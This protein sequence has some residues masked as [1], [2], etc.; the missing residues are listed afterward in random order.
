L[1]ST[2]ICAAAAAV[3]TAGG[4]ISVTSAVTGAPGLSLRTYVSEAGV[5]GYPHATAFRAGILA[6]A[7]GLAL[8]GVALLLR[9]APLAPA[10]L[11]AAAAAAVPAG[12]VRCTGGCP[13]PPYE[14]T[15][16]E[17]AV[18]GAASVLAVGAAVGAMLALARSGQDRFLRIAA[19]VAAAPVLPLGVVVGLALLLLGRGVVIGVI[20]RALLAIVGAWLLT[21]AL[22]LATTPQPTRRPP[23]PR[24]V[25]QG[26]P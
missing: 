9:R 10:L 13:L 26:P 24:A 4:A 22:R 2:R 3:C 6:L 20:E 5:L 15:T 19:R 12:A 16:A 1:T 7:A 23:H 11:F 14:M 18:H 25:D 21:T 8:L 17:D